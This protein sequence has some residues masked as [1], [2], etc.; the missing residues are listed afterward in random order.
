MDRKQAE[1]DSHRQRVIA[2]ART[3]SVCSPQ[4][5]TPTLVSAPHPPPH[6]PIL[7]NVAM[8]STGG[9][10]LSFSEAP[11]APHSVGCSL[12]VGMQRSSG[13]AS[14]LPPPP[15][16]QTGLWSMRD[17]KVVCLCKPLCSWKGNPGVWT[18]CLLGHMC[19]C[20]HGAFGDLSSQTSASPAEGLGSNLP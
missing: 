6:P 19:F 16:Q 18:P 10:S 13:G 9:D 20:G 7:S 17:R 5:V 12:G 4:A 8:D 14:F 2:T 15:T 11:V 1:S 3:A